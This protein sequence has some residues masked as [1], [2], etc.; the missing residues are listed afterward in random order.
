MENTD[1]IEK[2]FTADQVWSLNAY[3]DWALR[4]A[5][6]PYVCGIEHKG[7]MRFWRMPGFLIATQAGWVCSVCGYTRDWAWT[8]DAN[9]SWLN[10]PAPAMMG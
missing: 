2:P 8:K 1:T 6:E 5:N 3:Q 9:W 7:P 10:E 4:T